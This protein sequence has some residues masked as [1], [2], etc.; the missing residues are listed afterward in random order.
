MQSRAITYRRCS[1]SEQ[2][3]SGLGLEAQA[4]TITGALSARGWTVV[5]DAVD[6]GRSAKDLARPALLDALDRLDAGE[7][8]VLV[9]AKLDRLSRSVLDFS[10][11]MER[12][13][14]NGWALVCLDLGVDTTTPAGE[15]M[16]T[17]LAA[18]AQYERR[19]IGERTRSALQALKAKGKRLGRPVEI[20]DA[21]RARI[22]AARAAGH[23]LAAIADRLNAEHVPTARGG[24]WH[25]STIGRVLASVELD[26]A[27]SPIDPTAPEEGA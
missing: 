8:D 23:T 15:M 17:V 10:G 6:E 12:A 2:T 26:D 14:S 18:F 1:T 7:A 16:S 11:L 13:R 24:R 19:L 20:D 3:D 25:P 4:A 9:V 21:T 5:L 22:T 27:A